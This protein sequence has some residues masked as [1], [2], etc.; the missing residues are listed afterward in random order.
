MKVYIANSSPAYQRMWQDAGHQVV[1]TLKECDIVQFTGGSDVDPQ[2]YD[3]KP[4]MLTGSYRPRDDQ[5]IVI[6]NAAKKA[7]KPMVGICRGGQF[8]NVMCGGRMFQ[9]V[10]NHA[11]QGTHPMVDLVTGQEV[12]VS[13]T[14]HQMMRP[15]KKG[16]TVGVALN[17]A[18]T[19]Q[20]M[21][22][23]NDVSMNAIIIDDDEVDTEV[24]WY[25]ED[26]CL[27][28]QPHPEFNGVKE[29]REYYFELIQRYI[30]E[31]SGE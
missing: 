14:H 16:W 24:V 22:R 23:I 30:A 10:D 20:F 2:L 31:E 6:F 17:H 5:E 9:H 11:I 3:E 4:H 13:S 18:T 28:F 29:C 27:C 12:N 25:A 8:L 1:N 19:K 26:K 15:G 21:P 7:D